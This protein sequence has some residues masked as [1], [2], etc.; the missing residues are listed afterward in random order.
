MSPFRPILFATSYM[1]RRRRLGGGGQGFIFG[2]LASVIERDGFGREGFECLRQPIGHGPC[3]F[4]VR[5]VDDNEVARFALD[6]SDEVVF[7]TYTPA[8]RSGCLLW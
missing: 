4:A 7:M 6:G 5:V 8:S 2:K 3:V 1:G